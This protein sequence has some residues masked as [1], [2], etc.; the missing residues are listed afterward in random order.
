MST[1]DS[2]ALT[3]LCRSGWR[4]G[5]DWPSPKVGNS[6]FGLCWWRG[7][8]SV[9]NEGQE[10]SHRKPSVPSQALPQGMDRLPFLL[11]SSR[12][13]QAR[14]GI[15]H[16]WGKGGQGPRPSQ[17]ATVAARGLGP[18]QEGWRAGRSTWGWV[19]AMAHRG[20]GRGGLL[21][22]QARQ[23]AG[24]HFG[25]ATGLPP[26]LPILFRPLIFRIVTRSLLRVGI[27]G[28][29]GRTGWRPEVRGI[30]LGSCPL[31]THPVHGTLLPLSPGFTEGEEG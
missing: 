17:Q 27:R 28:G 21:P 25:G 26:C 29:N 9:E 7:R 4:P 6:C 16:C 1:A 23:G 22:L 14:A 20:G 24:R 3:C 15:L 11:A 8:Y 2:L 5:R 30:R 19:G 13:P 18:T 10:W 12:Q 31:K